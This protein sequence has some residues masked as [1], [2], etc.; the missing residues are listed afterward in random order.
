[1]E[2]TQT[3]QNG[4]LAVYFRD[5]IHALHQFFRAHAPSVSD[6]NNREKGDGKQEK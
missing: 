3:G 2:R 4:H 1:M 5:R 6:V